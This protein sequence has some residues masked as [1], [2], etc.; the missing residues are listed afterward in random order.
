MHLILYES[1]NAC[2]NLREK[3]ERCGKPKIQKVQ[4][5]GSVQQKLRNSLKFSHEF[6]IKKDF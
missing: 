5:R 2:I 6:F 1:I 3:K 4:S